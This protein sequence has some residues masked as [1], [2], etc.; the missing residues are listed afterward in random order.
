[1]LRLIAGGATNKEIG[2]A[3]GVSYR[4]IEDH[5]AKIMRKL[6]VRNVADLLRAVLTKNG[7]SI[8]RGFGTPVVAKY[9]SHATAILPKRT[10]ANIAHLRCLVGVMSRLRLK[11]AGCRLRAR[12]G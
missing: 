1:M 8:L 11:R 9:S 3:L 6:G 7:C 2:I 5:R 4:T 10:G 12:A